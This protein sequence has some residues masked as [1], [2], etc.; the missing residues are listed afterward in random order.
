MS[1]PYAVLYLL[2]EYFFVL[3]LSIPYPVIIVNFGT[4]NNQVWISICV[5]LEIAFF[6]FFSF[7]YYCT[8]NLSD[9]LLYNM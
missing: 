3:C 7:A 5:K 9:N 2:G 8:I 1:Q 4:E 6:F